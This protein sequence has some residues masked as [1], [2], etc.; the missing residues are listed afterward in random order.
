MW[1]TIEFSAPAQWDM[2]SWSNSTCLYVESCVERSRAMGLNIDLNFLSLQTTEEQLVERLHYGFFYLP[3]SSQT[4]VSSDLIR[5]W[6][7]VLDYGD[8]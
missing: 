3:S 8:L 7:G 4:E 5:E 6:L 2:L 1:N